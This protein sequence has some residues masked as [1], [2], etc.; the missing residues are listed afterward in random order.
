MAHT[1]LLT[2]QIPSFSARDNLSPEILISSALRMDLVNVIDQI[3]L[4]F[5][6]AKN[7]SLQGISKKFKFK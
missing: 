3:K 7:S 6:R 5:P 1:L 4:A 2:S